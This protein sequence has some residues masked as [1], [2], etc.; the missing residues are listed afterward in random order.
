MGD[1]EK[2]C[3]CAA[4]IQAQSD[5]RYQEQRAHQ[6]DIVFEGIKVKLEN[7]EEGMKELKTDVKIIKEKPSRKWESF[8]SVAFNW[9]VVTVLAIMAAKIGLL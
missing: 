6:T 2:D 5:I 8:T 4:V 1:T 9:L 3:P 7:I